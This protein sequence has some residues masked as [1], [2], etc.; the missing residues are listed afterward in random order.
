L[1]GSVKA[2]GVFRHITTQT[3][4]SGVGDTLTFGNVVG[5]GY[6]AN[7]N[8]AYN[9]GLTRLSSSTGTLPINNATSY[10]GIQIGWGQTRGT[11][12]YPDGYPIN[13]SRPANNSAAYGFPANTQSYSI[14]NL[15]SITYH[16][17]G[18]YTLN[19]TNGPDLAAGQLY[20]I[21]LIQNVGTSLPGNRTGGWFAVNTEAG[22]GAD[23]KVTKLYVGSI[24]ATGTELWADSGIYQF[25]ITW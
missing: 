6:A 5:P 10:Y 20:P 9:F 4:A 17:I 2:W 21:L 23:G 13:P 1:L 19:L 12:I 22:R 18:L 25:A 8:K 11:G 24:T 16:G 14:N 3:K 7:P 15:T